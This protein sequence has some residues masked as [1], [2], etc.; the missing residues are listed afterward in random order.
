MIFRRVVVER[1]GIVGPKVERQAALDWCVENGFAVEKEFRRPKGRG[2]QILAAR[3]M[4]DGRKNRWT[5]TA[6]Q[7]RSRN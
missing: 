3:L 1:I 2:F 4:R 5:A 7:L 6:K